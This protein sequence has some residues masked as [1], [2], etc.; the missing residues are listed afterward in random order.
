MNVDELYLESEADI[1]NNE[2]TEAFKK[3]EEI[4]YEVPD[5]APAHN[6][7][8]WIFKT[9]FDDYA[10]A[11]NHFLMAIKMAPM[12]PHPYFHY[13]TLLTDL[14]RW[15]DLDTHLLLCAK[16]PTLDKSWIYSKRAVM[17]ELTQDYD[18]AIKYNEQAIL[19]CI[20]DEKIRNY[21]DDIDRCFVKK[22]IVLRTK[23]RKR[24]KRKEDE[25]PF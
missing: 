5:H 10:R 7:M 17:Y 21:N 9:Q 13:A 6:S 1:K 11:E 14:E 4:L 15:E 22:S 25:L 2:Y 8:G 18:A 23:P 3:C 19:Y 20:S 24:T 16:V 12:Y